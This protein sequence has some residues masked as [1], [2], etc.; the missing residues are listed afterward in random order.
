[1]KIPDTGVFLGPNRG[2]Y[3][4]LNMFI[5]AR[6]GGL[7]KN[8]CKYLI[9]NYLH[10]C[11]CIWA[12]LLVCPR[13]LFF[14]VIYT[15][16]NMSLKFA[17]TLQEFLALWIMS[18]LVDLFLYGENTRSNHKLCSNCAFFKAA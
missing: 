14:E 17:D 6:G 1:M 3:L 4:I 7:N 9:F 12:T 18:A 5:W 16:K 8:K 10:V 2:K 13:D 11:V 15:K